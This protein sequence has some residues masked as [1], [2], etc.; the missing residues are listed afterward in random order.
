MASM[1]ACAINAAPAKTDE[2]SRRD[3]MVFPFTIVP[4]KVEPHLIRDACPDP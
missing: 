3:F 2:A 1:L 4:P